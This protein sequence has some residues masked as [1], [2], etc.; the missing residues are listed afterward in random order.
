[1]CSVTSPFGITSKSRLRLQSAAPSPL[2]FLASWRCQ[3]SSD[4]HTLPK[5]RRT[6]GSTT[7][8][9]SRPSIPP[10]ARC[11]L[12]TLRA[13]TAYYRGFGTLK[14]SHSMGL[15]CGSCSSLYGP[16]PSAAVRWDADKVNFLLNRACCCVSIPVALAGLPPFVSHNTFSEQP[17]PPRCLFQARLPPNLLGSHGIPQQPALVVAL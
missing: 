8:L 5:Q 9:Y 14:Y 11:S 3:F 4:I 12:R 7:A 2:F 16:T 10:L 17:Y 6:V 1:M 15:V 13:R